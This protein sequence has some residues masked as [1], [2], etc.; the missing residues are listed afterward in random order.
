MPKESTK[1]REPVF[2]LDNNCPMCGHS[3][4]MIYKPD[5][6]DGNID[7]VCG[8]VSNPMRTNS[9]CSEKWSMTTTR[10]ERRNILV[11]LKIAERQ[12]K[13]Y[14][15]ISKNRKLLGYDYA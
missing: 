4:P 9:P 10:E 6:L 13:L 11:L 3:S 5:L 1:R 8:S 7:C 12:D 14:K 15:E 2:W